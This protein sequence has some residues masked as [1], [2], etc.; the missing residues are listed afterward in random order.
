MLRRIGE[1]VKTIFGLVESVDQLK[2][3]HDVL[4]ADVEMLR[5]ELERQAGQVS[6]LMEF[7]HDAL[8]KH[9]RRE[10][11]AAARTAI[12]ELGRERRGRKK[13]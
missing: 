1:A 4:A 6:V 3:K 2:A 10:A 13:K 9:M 8:N 12:A 11:E 5:R 7:V